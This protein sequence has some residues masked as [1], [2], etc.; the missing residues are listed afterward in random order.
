MKRIKIILVIVALIIAE[1]LTFTYIEW[2]SNHELKHLFSD[3]TNNLKIKEKAAKKAYILLS[4]N[5]FEQTV[6]K[7][8]I[9][10]LLATRLTLDNLGV[11]KFQSC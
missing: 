11:L 4:K 9:L 7:P 5:I 2:F 10:E 6:N 3:H 1:V 8:E